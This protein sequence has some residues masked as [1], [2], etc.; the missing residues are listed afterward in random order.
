MIQNLITW[1]YDRD[2]YDSPGWFPLISSI[3][4]PP[5][6]AA[7]PGGRCASVEWPWWRRVSSHPEEDNPGLCQVHFIFGL[8]FVCVFVYVTRLFQFNIKHVRSLY[9][10]LFFCSFFCLLFYQCKV[11]SH[12]FLAS[13]E[14]DCKCTVT[15]Q[16]LFWVFIFLRHMQ[17]GH[18]IRSSTRFKWIQINT[19]VS[20]SVKCL[21]RFLV[22]V[23]LSRAVFCVYF[24]LLSGYSA[25]R[26]LSEL[27]FRVF[28]FCLRTFF[29]KFVVKLIK[30]RQWMEERERVASD[31]RGSLMLVG[32]AS[33]HWS[34]SLLSPRHIWNTVC[35]TLSLHGSMERESR[36][37]KAEWRRR[38]RN[39]RGSINSEYGVS[40]RAWT[41]SNPE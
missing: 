26:S 38:R 14:N 11:L 31:M 10:I 5:C 40:Q 27:F 9:V 19:I 32:V 22:R 35:L 7:Y 8:S 4:P 16:V 17:Y 24:R 28:L 15:D 13:L 1:H 41:R 3:S 12:L 20:L 34:C 29:F 30:P 2:S 36:K 39:C 23:S 25:W 21:L 6:Q 37:R 18:S 33:T